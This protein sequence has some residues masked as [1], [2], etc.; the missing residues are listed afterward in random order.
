V[1]NQARVQQ[2]LKEFKLQEEQTGVA[3]QTAQANLKA[4]Q[5]SAQA[6]KARLDSALTQAG[7]QKELTEASIESARS[8]L[9]AETERL[10]Q[11]K[12]ATLSQGKTTA[13]A[14]L[15]QAEA[16]LKNAELQLNRQ[17]ALLAKGFVAQS[18]V[19]Q[20]Q[21]TYDVNYA[22]FLTAQQRI[23]TLKPE[24]DAD[25][26]AQEARVRQVAAQVRT[27]EAQRMDIELRNQNA[28][29]SA[30]DYKRALADVAQAQAQLRQ[31]RANRLNNS[32]R[33]TQIEQAK[34]SGARAQASMTNA[35]VQLNDTRVTAPRD[36]VI[37]KKYVEEGT[38][39]S[40]GISFNSTGTTILQLGDISRMYVDVTVDETDVASVE[41]DQKVDVVLDAY[42]TSPIEGKVVK[43]EPQA[44]V[45]QNVTTV[46]VRVEVDNS[47]AV[48]RLL[49]PGMNATCEFIVD[50]KEDVI[51]CPNEA[52]RTKADG[53]RYV[54]I[55]SG[56]KVAPPDKDTGEKDENLKVD[57]K[58]EERPVK[59]GL[60]GNDA[61]E[62]EE[63]LKEGDV[64]VTQ[65][66]EPA[67][68]TA[69]GGGN[70]FGGGRG[71]GRR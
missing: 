22:N 67:P 35:Q 59:V 27:A 64:I 63:G 9:A 40:S 65:V 45:E 46:H 18:A 20:A 38:F 6:A 4:A 19:D 16:N 54:E 42:A 55:A 44:T 36:G 34:A 56:G 2:T 28:A 50:R 49:K 11:M 3:I 43:I 31:A 47:S 48:Y 21:A 32:I 33:L 14:T 70:P 24:Q 12:N 61:T 58:L 8:T 53:T 13:E 26:K 69:G 71:P 41:M 39:I 62:V 15:R 52:L 7:A 57:V 51:A 37:L 66:I 30:A 60:E 23:N 68:P 1:S 5:A 25:L 10:N 29:S 17:K